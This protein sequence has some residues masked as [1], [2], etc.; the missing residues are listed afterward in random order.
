MDWFLVCHWFSLSV[1]LVQSKGHS[2]CDSACFAHQ[3]D[4]GLGLGKSLLC[5]Q[6]K[7]FE[8]F[9]GVLLHTLAVGVHHTYRL[10]D[11]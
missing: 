8:R 3:V 1:F 9:L 5:C 11:K 10:S 6:P 4:G 7:P 2:V